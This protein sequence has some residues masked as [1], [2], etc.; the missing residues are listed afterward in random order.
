MTGRRRF[1]ICLTAQS[2]KCTMD[3]TYAPGRPFCCESKGD[4][5]SRGQGR[6]QMA[7]DKWSVK[8]SSWGEMAGDCGRKEKACIQ[9]TEG[10]MDRI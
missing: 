2:A 1:S 4:N 6:G 10:R 3:C 5:D 8:E 9:E 7:G